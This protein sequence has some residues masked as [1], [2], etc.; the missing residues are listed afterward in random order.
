MLNIRSHQGN[1]IKTTRSYNLIP[2]RMAIIKKTNMT[3]SGFSFLQCQGLNSGPH[4]CY[5]GALP[6][7]PLHCPSKMTNSGEDIEKREVFYTVGGNVN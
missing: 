2:V 1:A 5:M 3:N 7:V 4:S 6:L